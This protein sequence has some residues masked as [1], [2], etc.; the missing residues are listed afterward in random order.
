MIKTQAQNEYTLISKDGEEC[1]RG[2]D[3]L[4]IR[5]FFIEKKAGKAGYKIGIPGYKT[6][7]TF[8][9]FTNIINYKQSNK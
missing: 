9:E 3:V 1:G 8:S 4:M 7:F 2:Y 6:P 5:T